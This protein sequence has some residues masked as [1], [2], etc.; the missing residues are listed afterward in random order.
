MIQLKNY[1]TG[2]SISKQAFRDKTIANAFIGINSPQNTALKRQYGFKWNEG[3]IFLYSYITVPDLYLKLIEGHSICHLFDQ[4]TD[5]PGINN[6]IHE[7]N[8]DGG[9]VCI[10]FR[11]GLKRD[12]FFK[13]A[14]L[15]GIDLD[16]SNISLS[17]LLSKIPGNYKPSI[18]YTTFSNL[19]N[20]GEYRLRLIY[21]FFDDITGGGKFWYRYVGSKVGEKL[22]EYVPDAVIDT[23][24]LSVSQCIHGTNY[25]LPGFEGGFTDNIYEPYDFGCTLEGYY[26]TLKMGCQYQLNAEGLVSDLRTRDEIIAE[27]VRLREQYEEIANLTIDEAKAFEKA[28]EDPEKYIKERNEQGYLPD[29]IGVF[30]EAVAMREGIIQY[31]S[32]RWNIHKY[33]LRPSVDDDKWIEG[34]YYFIDKD[35]YLEIPQ[36]RTAVQDQ[37]HRRQKLY[38][39]MVLR[40]YLCPNISAEGLLWNACEDVRR[41]YFDNSDGVITMSGLINDVN[42]TLALPWG[43]AMEDGVRKLI[44]NQ[45]KRSQPKEGIIYKK[46]I[47]YN[48]ARH[49]AHMTIIDKY[50]DWSKTMKENQKLLND[51]PEISFNVGKDMLMEYRKEYEDRKEV[52]IMEMIDLN[53]SIRGNYYRIRESGYGVSYDKFKEL[54]NEVLSF[55]TSL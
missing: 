29:R 1:R 35:T 36:Y 16:H 41:G 33:I 25:S 17:E 10:G 52:I 2:V 8:A 50:Y 34:Y 45:K 55:F 53:E 44:E 37:H 28:I 40:R 12:E 20:P 4:P 23:S 11:K 14:C 51:N 6:L 7:K 9:N 46:G 19:K 18:S 13:K 3:L 30:S 49:N 42:R 32:T 27:I 54:Y 31:A 47:D 26:K 24:L 22:L 15:V 48:R 38:Y 39:R 43:D 5:Y 21:V